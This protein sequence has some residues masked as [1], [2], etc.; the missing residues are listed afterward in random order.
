MQQRSRAQQRTYDR[1]LKESAAVEEA[2]VLEDAATVLHVLEERKLAGSLRSK[3]QKF[4]ARRVT[5][6]ERLLAFAMC[7]HARL[8]ARSPARV[9]SRDV[10]GVIA[11]FV[12]GVWVVVAGGAEM[13]P[14]ERGADDDDEQDLE[15]EDHRRGPLNNRRF[16]VHDSPSAWLWNGHHE[17]VSLPDMLTPVSEC[18]LHYFAAEKE[19]WCLGAVDGAA[20]P[21]AL[22][23]NLKNRIWRSVE[24]VIT[25]PRRGAT[26][27]VY[28]NML[29]TFGGEIGGQR[30]RDSQ[31]CL[32]GRSPWGSRALPDRP[33]ILDHWTFALPILLGDMLLVWATGVVLDE[34]GNDCHV[35][36]LSNS[37]PNW[38]VITGVSGLEGIRSSAMFA[39][40]GKLYVAGGVMETGCSTCTHSLSIMRQLDFDTLQWI[41]LSKSRVPESVAYCTPV[42][43]QGSVL[44][45]GGFDFS[46]FLLIGAQCLVYRFDT[47][48]KTWKRV[49]EQRNDMLD[50]DDTSESAVRFPVRLVHC[51]VV[52]ISS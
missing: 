14:K 16:T 13:R 25:P 2:H 4:C 38:C 28:K 45:C 51:G 47:T 50:E 21:N 5:R 8:G 11:R 24:D 26:S 1:F 19:V 39:L 35:V 42:N 49:G 34:T 33:G 6:L 40:D 12:P 7:R 44:L 10:M 30:I 43:A 22:V 36:D 32:S 9:L 20:S 3:L 27:I 15:Y 48:R 17:W 46:G 41:E 31:F 18:Q 52:Q 37:C 29:L 23:L